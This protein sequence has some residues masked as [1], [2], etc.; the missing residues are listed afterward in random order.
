[1][2]LLLCFILTW[3]SNAPETEFVDRV[4]IKVNDKIITQRELVM[5]YEQRRQGYLQ[6][7]RGA[8]L[9]EKLK[10]AWEDTLKEAQEQ[11][12]LYENAVELGMALSEEDVRSRLNA[13]R[14]SNGLSEQE[15]EEIIQEQTGMSMHDFIEF[16][17]RQD[18]ADTVIHT[19]VVSQIKIDDSE[20]AKH[21][22]E[23]REDY[24]NPATYRIAEIVLLKG[25]GDPLA[26][27]IKANSAAEFLKKGGDFTEAAQMYSDSSSKE[28]GGDLGI[29]Q[30]GDL[31]KLIE[32]KVNAM[33]LNEVSEVFE[34]QTAYFIIKLLD[35][36]PPKPK[37]IQ[38]VR[39]DIVRELR[40]PRM[41][42]T[43]A[44]Y[45]QDLKN[46][47]LLQ[48]KTRKPPKDLAE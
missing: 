45:L 35:R 6:A 10:T 42:S 27:K 15:F 36:T 3:Q 28:S 40:M 44:T 48:V 21:H 22:S 17:K 7:Y 1:M 25:E 24:L 19:K 33:A 47:Y 26:A 14:E 11:L 8:Q 34:T 43:M 23:H 46:K 37:P 4:A 39:D 41:E 20:I 13:M 32:D 16:R 29:V 38:E 31:N 5:M 9:D 18:S 30:Y 12:L 2:A